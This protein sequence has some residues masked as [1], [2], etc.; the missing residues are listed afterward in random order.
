MICLVGM[1]NPYLG[2]EPLSPR[3]KNSSGWRLWKMLNDRCGLPMDQYEAAFTRYN[4]FN[5][6]IWYDDRAEENAECIKDDFVRGDV[7]ILLGERVCGA[8]G[9]DKVLI[10]PQVVDGVEYRV[11]PHPS[12][13]CRFYNEPLYRDLVAMMLEDL[14]ER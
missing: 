5:G 1:C 3:V 12:G 8:M 14:S 11:I 7:A 9:V 2:A 6:P 10:H 13:L 4:L